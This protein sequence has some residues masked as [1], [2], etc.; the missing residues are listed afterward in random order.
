MSYRSNDD[1]FEALRS[2]ID[3]WCDRRSFRPLSRILGPYIS[4]NGMTDGWTELATGLKAIRAVDR[5]QLTASELT[6]VDDLIRLIDKAI[7]GSSSG[8][9]TEACPS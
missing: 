9:Q 6:T 7:Y 4:F 3:A 8:G 2:L 1:I 5:D